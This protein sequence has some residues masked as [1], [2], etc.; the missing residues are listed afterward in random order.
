M[1][2]MMLMY[3]RRQAWGF[4]ALTQTPLTHMSYR[5]LS[6]TARRDQETTSFLRWHRNGQNARGKK[7]LPGFY[8]AWNS[9]A[10]QVRPSVWTEWL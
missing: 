7:G 9:S 8:A 10:A 3:L 2:T 1:L 6:D 5:Q 4:P